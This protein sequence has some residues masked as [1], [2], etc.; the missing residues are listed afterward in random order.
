VSDSSLGKAGRLTSRKPQKHRDWERSLEVSGPS[1]Y[2]EQ[3]QPG[4]VAQDLVQSCL[5]T[6][7]DRDSAASLG[8]SSMSEHPS[9]DSLFHSSNWDFSVCQHGA[10]A[11]HPPTREH[12]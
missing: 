8:T 4:Q 2:S 9:G 12:F 7:K 6:L 10:G 3:P 5:D 1:S 11:A